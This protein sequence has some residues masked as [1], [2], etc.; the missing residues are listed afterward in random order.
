LRPD[1]MATDPP[2]LRWYKSKRDGQ[3]GYMVERHGREMIRLDRPA[4]DLVEPYSDALWEPV[5]SERPVN[6][7]QVARIAFAADRALCQMLALH[8]EV[9]KEWVGLTDKERAAWV[10]NGPPADPPMRQALYRLIVGFFP[11]A[12]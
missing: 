6:R 4:Q 12:V 1:A 2:P 7:A 5:S 11:G 8:G 3:L 10:A 9:R